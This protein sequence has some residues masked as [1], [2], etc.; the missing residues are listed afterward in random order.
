MPAELESWLA[1]FAVA[2]ARITAALTFVPLPGFREATKIP[3]VILAL[4]LALILSP[5][6]P[7]SFGR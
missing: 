4:C 2:L 7:R 1:Q 6:L 3:R 5:A